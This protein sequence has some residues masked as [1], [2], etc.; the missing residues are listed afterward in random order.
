MN[1]YLRENITINNINQQEEWYLKLLI[2]ENWRYFIFLENPSEELQEFAI[3]R[4]AGAALKF[5]KNPSEK[6]ILKALR[7]DAHNIRFIKNPSDDLKLFALRENGWA[8]QHI[9]NPSEQMQL[10]AINQTTESLQYIKKPL[11]VKDVSLY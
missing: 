9:E 10:A 1:A 11:F 2:K 6:F 3:E 4:S 8:I 5:I 7:E